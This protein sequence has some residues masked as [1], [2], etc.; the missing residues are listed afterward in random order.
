MKQDV[1]NKIVVKSK[2]KSLNNWNFV[3]KLLDQEIESHKICDQIMK[4]YIWKK[5]KIIMVL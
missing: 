5:R 4:A 1:Q 2:K 3:G